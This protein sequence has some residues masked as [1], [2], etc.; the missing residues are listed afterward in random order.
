MLKNESTL[1]VVLYEGEGAAPLD[2][3]LATMTALLE[4]GYAVTRSLSRGAVAP[5][6]RGSLS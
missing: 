1:R 3:R 6:T 2:D 5:Q 4:R